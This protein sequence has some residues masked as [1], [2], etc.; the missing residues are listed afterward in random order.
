MISPLNS[1]WN[2]T[3]RT[4]TGCNRIMQEM[5]R[6]QR[7]QL[8]SCADGSV[9]FSSNVWYLFQKCYNRCKD[10]CRGQNKYALLG[11]WMSSIFKMYR[12]LWKWI[13][14]HPPICLCNPSF[15]QWHICIHMP[16]TSQSPRTTV[17]YSDCLPSLVLQSHTSC[18][19]PHFYSGFTGFRR[20]KPWLLSVFCFKHWETL[21]F[22]DMFPY[23][24]S[25]SFCSKIYYFLL[26]V[27]VNCM[28]FSVSPLFY[29]FL[30]FVTVN[31]QW[32]WTFPI[33]FRKKKQK[34][35]KSPLV[36]LNV[37]YMSNDFLVKSPKTHLFVST[38]S[39]RFWGTAWFD[40]VGCSGIRGVSY[41]TALNGGILCITA[42]VMII[43]YKKI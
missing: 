22:L 17:I 28:I 39:N 38:E 30:L 25:S 6:F 24:G 42:G 9:I 13:D 8:L 33:K 7:F 1:Q 12:S 16:S 41:F 34:N 11:R 20:R 43:I 2:R 21:G 4:I 15:V 40:L 36:P 35:I 27:T 18:V 23:V 32:S 31:C 26:F 29:D 3:T 37:N 19:N 14:D 5:W 10:I